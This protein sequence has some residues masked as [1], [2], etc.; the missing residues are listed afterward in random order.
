MQNHI[1]CDKSQ[2]SVQYSRYCT[3]V[4][5]EDVVFI[6]MLQIPGCRPDD[7]ND[8]QGG[9]K[10]YENWEEPRE[11]VFLRFGS[12]PVYEAAAEFYAYIAYPDPLEKTQRE[13]YRIA[14]SRWAVLE[15]G[16]IDKKWNESIEGPIWPII[17]SQS[18]KVFEK[19]YQDGSNTW[20]RR[21]IC[22]ATILFPDLMEELLDGLAPTVGNL[23]GMLGNRWGYSESSG[24]TIELRIWRPTKPVAHAAAAAIYTLSILDDSK[25]EW[26]GE[27][28]LCYQ[29][30]FLATL[31]YEDVFRNILLHLTSNLYLQVPSCRRF[32]IAS[33]DMINFALEL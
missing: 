22:A 15:R 12:L 19:T 4:Q 10:T 14:L 32:K 25:H 7:E 26:D 17:F 27:R 28:Q 13:K 23:V 9:L 31:F 3:S 11:T 16:K 8:N 29:Q 20:W 2:I 24:K 1:R 33:G 21:G 6:P 5:V 18:Q 30:P